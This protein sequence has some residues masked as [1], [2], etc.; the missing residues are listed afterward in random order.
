VDPVVVDLERPEGV[1]PVV[2]DLERPVPVDL[3]RPAGVD[4]VG[5][6]GLADSPCRPM[7]TPTEYPCAHPSPKLD[8][9]S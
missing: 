4:P 3:E 2:V 1:D 8:A 7:G 9:V 5:L 6:V